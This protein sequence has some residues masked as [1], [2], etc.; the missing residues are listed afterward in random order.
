MQYRTDIALIHANTE[1]GRRNHDVQMVILPLADQTLALLGVGFAVEQAKPTEALL[2][3]QVS[4][5][6]RIRPGR[7]VKNQRSRQ[8]P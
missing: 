1:G 7:C 4:P 5:V 3:Q 8:A 6:L 2:D